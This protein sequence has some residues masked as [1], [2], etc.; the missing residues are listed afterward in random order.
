MPQAVAGPDLSGSRA[1]ALLGYAG[2]REAG[3]SAGGPAGGGGGAR[4]GLAPP[5]TRAQ[6]SCGGVGGPLCRAAGGVLLAT[7][8]H[9]RSGD[10][11]DPPGSS[12]SCPAP[13][14]TCRPCSTPAP[15]RR[16]ARRSSPSART[17]TASRGL[18]RAGG[19]GRADV[20]RRA[21]RLPDRDDVGRRRSPRGRARTS[22]TSSSRAG[23]MKILSAGGP[24][25]F[26]TGT[27][28]P[29]PRCCRRSRAR[30]RSRDA[31]ALRREGHRRAPSTSSTPASTPGRSSPRRRCRSAHDDDEASLHERIKV[32][33]RR[34]LVDV[35]GRLVRDGWTVIGKKGDDPVMTQRPT[36]AVRRALVSVYDKTGL[37]RARP[38]AGRGR[39]RDR[40]DRLDRGAASPRPACR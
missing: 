26:P 21:G 16:T 33:E 24:R 5:A 11:R 35:V 14:P 28:T 18:E 38:R 7:G 36:V 39:G 13:A 8:A 32:V 4:P 19:G 34:L 12:S 3:E 17:G 29:T 20:R 6:G 22:P 1:V 31:L 37:R 9:C 25:R 10:A 23:F 30:T 2:R 15:T 27:S 40:V